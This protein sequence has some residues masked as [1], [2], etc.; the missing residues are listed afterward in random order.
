MSPTLIVVETSTGGVND[1]WY[2][3]TIGRYVSVFYDWLKVALLVNGVLSCCVKRYSSWNA[4]T[5]AYEE[6]E[7]A[8]FVQICP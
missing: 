2:T 7:H 4:A 6:A 5:D 1:M 3:V 8:G